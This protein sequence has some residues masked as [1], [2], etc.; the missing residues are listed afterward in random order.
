MS[1][2]EVATVVPRSASLVGPLPDGP[3]PP[4]RMSVAY[5]HPM[6][7]ASVVVAVQDVAL[8]LIM[9]LGCEFSVTRVHA[10]EP[11]V[12]ANLAGLSGVASTRY[13]PATMPVSTGCWTSW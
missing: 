7:L 6:Q 10:E 3:R 1:A 13:A 11:S 9:V 8:R 4:S 12:S 5:S 2:E